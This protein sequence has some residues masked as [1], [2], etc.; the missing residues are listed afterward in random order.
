VFHGYVSEFVDLD[1]LDEVMQSLI[2]E[3][4][5]DATA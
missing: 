1:Q 3:D 5:D 4:E 2:K